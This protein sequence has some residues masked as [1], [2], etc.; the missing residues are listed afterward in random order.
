VYAA[1]RLVVI[2]SRQ[3]V[4]LT[5]RCVSGGSNARFSL[6]SPVFESFSKLLNGE[7]ST[8]KLASLSEIQTS[9]DLNQR[10]QAESLIE[11]LK[12]L[13]CI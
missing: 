4:E 10:N 3:G 7:I 6:G 5:R 11:P 8:L 13:R 2:S 9:R 12:G 1:L